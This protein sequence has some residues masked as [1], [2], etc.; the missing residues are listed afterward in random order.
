MVDDSENVVATYGTPG[1]FCL[2]G[3]S[4]TRGYYN[5]P[6]ATRDSFDSDGFLHTGDIC[7]CDE[8]TKKW[9]IVGR[10][11]VRA[12]NLIHCLP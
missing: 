3:P 11:K 9:Y 2:R 8:N 1:E 6:K 5:N 7:V 4:I 10:K 12:T